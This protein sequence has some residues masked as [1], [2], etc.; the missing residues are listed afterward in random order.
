LDEAI[1]NGYDQEK[2]EHVLIFSDGTYKK[3]VAN[4]YD[5]RCRQVNREYL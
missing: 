2:K 4:I 1:L 5:M 3:V